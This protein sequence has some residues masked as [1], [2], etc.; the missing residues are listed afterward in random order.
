MTENYLWGMGALT[1][2]VLIT[3]YLAIFGRVDRSDEHKSTSH[4]ISKKH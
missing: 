4:R 2:L 1:L 3:W